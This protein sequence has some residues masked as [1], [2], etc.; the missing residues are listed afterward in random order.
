MIVKFK[1]EHVAEAEI[2]VQFDNE[3]ETLLIENS[4]GKTTLSSD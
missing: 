2:T 3:Q 4:L 1:N